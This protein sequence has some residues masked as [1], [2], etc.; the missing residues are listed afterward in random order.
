MMYAWTSKCYYMDE[1][2]N[3]IGVRKS[4]IC[5][6]KAKEKRKLAFVSKHLHLAFAS[7]HFQLAF[8]SKH[9]QARIC[10]LRLHLAFAA[11]ICSL[12]LHLAFAAC[13]FILHLQLVFASC[14]CMQAFADYRGSTLSNNRKP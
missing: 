2:V 14:I 6:D 7:K 13:I 3:K 8:A 4:E 9:L 12:H 1:I 11:C 5:A 10:S